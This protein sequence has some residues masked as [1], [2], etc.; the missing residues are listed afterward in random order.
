MKNACFIMLCCMCIAF[1]ANS[2]QSDR[3]LGLRIFGGDGSGVK[4]SY[5][6]FLTAGN[7]L[8]ADLGIGGGSNLFLMDISVFYQWVY[9]LENDL[10]WYIG[11]GAGLGIYNYNYDVIGDDSGIFLNAFGQLGI[12]YYFDIPLQLSFDLQPRIS[13]INNYNDLFDMGAGVALRYVF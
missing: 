8:E 3:A 4:I 6:Q 11:P 13:I 12:E 9:P 1:K 5:Q 7:R 10:Y 2:Q